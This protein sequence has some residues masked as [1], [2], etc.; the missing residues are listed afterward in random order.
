M[1]TRF[2]LLNI[3]VVSEDPV[4]LFLRSQAV[5]AAYYLLIFEF[6]TFGF[7]LLQNVTAS[8]LRV[9]TSLSTAVVMASW[10]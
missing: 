2:L 1:R 8:V 7:I 10:I 9:F 3:H 5:F 4:H 6:S